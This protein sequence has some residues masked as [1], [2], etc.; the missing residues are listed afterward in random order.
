MSDIT[1]DL[2]NASFWQLAY[3]QFFY[4]QPA[5]GVNPNAYHPIPDAQVPFLFDRHIL[6]VATS[7]TK[8]KPHWYLAARLIQ[9]ITARGTEFIDANASRVNIGLNRTQLVVLPKFSADYKIRFEIPWWHEEM[10]FAVWE[11]TGPE[12]DSTEELIQTLKVDIA[13]IE[14]KIGSSQ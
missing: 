3:D 1:R 13:R 10:G 7:S 9:Q 12:S 5:P 6:T 2:G 14:F 11:Y 8:V 4:A